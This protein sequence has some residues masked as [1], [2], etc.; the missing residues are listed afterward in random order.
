M[1]CAK[2]QIES[3]DYPQEAPLRREYAEMGVEGFSEFQEHRWLKED[4]TGDNSYRGS[5]RPTGFC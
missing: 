4:L 2:L 3:T 5:F 1:D